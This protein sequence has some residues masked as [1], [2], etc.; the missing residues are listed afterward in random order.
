MFMR[1]TNLPF[2]GGPMLRGPLTAAGMLWARLR[3]QF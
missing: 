2:P 1:L 3:D